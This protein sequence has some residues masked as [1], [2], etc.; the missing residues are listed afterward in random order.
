MENNELLKIYRDQ[1]DT[2][3]KELIYLFFRRFEIVKQIWLVK[4][5]EKIQPLDNNRWQTL[6]NENLEVSREFWLNDQFIID[7]WNRIHS[8]SLNIEK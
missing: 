5:Q 4:K 8:E 2:L 1:I 6:L 7:I 3:D